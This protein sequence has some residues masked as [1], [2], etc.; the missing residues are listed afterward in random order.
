MPSSPP[1]T[2]R[3]ATSPDPSLPCK[4]C[5]ASGVPDATGEPP[6]VARR[7]PPSSPAGRGSA[8]VRRR[9]LGG[10]SPAPRRCGCRTPAPTWP[11]PPPSPASRPRSC[12]ARSRRRSRPCAWARS[13]P[14]PHRG[15]RSSGSRCWERSSAAVKHLNGKAR[16][17]PS[18]RRSPPPPRRARLRLRPRIPGAPRAPAAPRRA[19]GER[20]S[21]AVARP[22]CRSEARDVPAPPAAWSRSGRRTSSRRDHARTEVHVQAPL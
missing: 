6:W 15:S 8:H 13:P 17:Q 12:P 2:V 22:S 3:N 5:S 11:A 9:R 7:S 4:I 20:G 10:S 14:R 18:Q 19:C 16:A 1:S 21:L